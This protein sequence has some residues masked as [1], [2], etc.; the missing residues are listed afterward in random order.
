MKYICTFIFCCMVG[1]VCNGQT[2][3]L[4]ECIASGIANN[5][6]LSNA[7]IDIDKGRTGVSQNRSRLLPVI[8][9]VF[10]ITDYLKSPV[11]VTTGTLLGNDFPDNP[12]W[13]TIQS[14]QYNASA[15]IQL[16]MPLYNQ[17]VL[18]AIDVARTVEKIN[19]LSYA[20]AVEDLTMQI[21][22]VYYMAQA[23]RKQQSL[24]DKNIAR[25]EDLCQITEAL[26]GQGV[27]MEVDLN[28]VR[29]NLQALKTQRGRCHTLYEQQLN[30]LRFLMNVT[31]ETP[32][33]V[34]YMAED[35]DTVH[36]AG[37]SNGLPELLLAEKQK[38]LAEKRIKTVRAGYLPTLSLTGYAGTLGYQEKFNHFFH[39]SASS[40]NWFGNC[41]IGLSVRIPLFE[42][43]SKKLQIKQY[44]YDAQQEANRMDLLKKQLNENYADALLQL[45]HNIEVFRTQSESYRQAEDVYNVTEEQ[46]KAGVASM[47]ALLQDEMQLRTAQA[48]CVQAHC[49]CNLAQLDLLKLSG[50][51]SQLSE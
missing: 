49:Q 3:T 42:A 27:V 16:S 21:S 43:N 29:I 39:T 48:A 33:N 23:S 26:Y 14:M 10:Q 17:T 20:K 28:R 6:S 31:Q 7:R 30:L 51:L 24:S 5:L 11:N 34:A 46:Y 35:V 13:Q 25:M 45:E 12:T 1:S 19:T 32:L 41:Y 50:N 47:T 36:L 2:M 44:R 8:N 18:A 37:I 4:K 38:E 9:G 22:K 40:D 15:G